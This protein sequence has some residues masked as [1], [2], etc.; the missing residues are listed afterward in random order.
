MQLSIVRTRNVPSRAARATMWAHAGD[1][2]GEEQLHVGLDPIDHLVAAHGVHVREGRLPEEWIRKQTHA[3]MCARRETEGIEAA[4]RACIRFDPVNMRACVRRLETKRIK[5]RLVFIQPRCK[6]TNKQ[7]NAR[8]RQARSV[9][10]T[11]GRLLGSVDSLFFSFRPLRI[12]RAQNACVHVPR[13]L[14]A[15]PQLCA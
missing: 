9:I 5:R 3:R 14:A 11:H 7:T 4:G 10:V 1:D 12:R 2:A 13:R 6:Q 15:A 8:A